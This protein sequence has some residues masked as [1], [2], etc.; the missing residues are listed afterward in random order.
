LNESGE[1]ERRRRERERE[2]GSFLIHCPAL[3]GLDTERGRGE[4]GKDAAS[5][6]SRRDEE[7]TTR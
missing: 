3:L 5:K 6:K 1:G 4:G 2:V 7:R